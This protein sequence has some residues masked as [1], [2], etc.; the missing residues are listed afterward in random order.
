MSAFRAIIGLLVAVGICFG[1][2]GVG[3]AF[4]ARAIPTWYAQLSK[5]AWT[6]PGWLFGPV[7]SLLYLMMGVAAWL[8][9]RRGA[10]AAVAAPLALFGVQ[11]ALNVAW[12]GLFFGLRRP[13]TAFAEIVVLWCSIA[14]TLFAF[15]RVTPSAG[16]LMLPY[17]AWVTYASALNFTIWR[18]NA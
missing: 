10:S 1:A 16:W 2:A 6:P 12:S 7:W 5:P 3:G 15:W 14:A 17:L 4:T 18:M 13:G 9:W 8:V 11:L